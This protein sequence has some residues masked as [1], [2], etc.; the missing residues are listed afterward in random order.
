[1]CRREDFSVDFCAKHVADMIRRHA[2]D[3]RA[4]IVGNSTGGGWAGFA[5]ARNYPELV[6]SL[7]ISAAWPLTG[8]RNTIAHSPRLIYTGLWTLL[9]S[10]A[11]KKKFFSASGLHGEYTNDKLF[12][13]IKGNVS[14]RLAKAGLCYGGLGY[15]YLA[16]ASEAGI[17]TV[18]MAPGL[19]D[20]IPHARKAGQCIN[21]VEN[22]DAVVFVVPGAAH[23]WN[24]QFPA[25]F[26]KTI[27]C[28]VD[29]RP[30]PTEL[31]ALDL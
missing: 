21:A 3:G 25:L 5:M 24:L 4:H 8:L 18:I 14:S 27:Q 20:S 17:R 9:H 13:E 12:A 23:A 7:Y 15:E 31:E 10:P 30:M 16:E 22:G 28:W 11:G 26:A 6:K 1:M 2:H 19:H 29:G